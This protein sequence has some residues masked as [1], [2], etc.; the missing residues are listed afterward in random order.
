MGQ[1]AHEVL[2]PAGSAASMATATVRGAKYAV[3]ISEGADIRWRAD[4]TVPT[5]AVGFPVP[6]DTPIEIRGEDN[7][8]NFSVIEQA[9]TSSFTCET[10]S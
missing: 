8:R 10:F 9:G 7:L 6:A 3:C 2:A 4:G 5:S 1:I